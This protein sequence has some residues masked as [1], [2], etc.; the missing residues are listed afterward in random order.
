[1][2][3]F[4]FLTLL[5]F[6][7]HTCIFFFIKYYSHGAGIRKEHQATIFAFCPAGIAHSMNQAGHKDYAKVLS[8]KRLDYTRE[9]FVYIFSF[10]RN[11]FRI[12]FGNIFFDPFFRNRF[13][14][15]FGNIFFF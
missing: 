4:F 3:L 11:R 13:R 7:T 14:I 5:F 1:M 6:E 15:R 9:L 10:F 2:L 8:L 12:R